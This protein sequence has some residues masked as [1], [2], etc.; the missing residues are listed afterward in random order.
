[1][2]DNYALEFLLLKNSFAENQLLQIEFL[3][4]LII[5]SGVLWIVYIGLHYEKIRE[6]FTV[7]RYENEPQNF[8][9]RIKLYIS[10]PLLSGNGI[11]MWRVYASIPLAITTVIF[12]K[13][14]VVNS[15]L[16]VVYVFLFTTDALDGAVARFLNN[17]TNLGKI[18]DPFADKFLDLMPLCIVS[19]FSGNSFFVLVASLIC[20]IDIA[21]QNLRAKTSNP[22]ANRVGKTKTVFKI[23]TIYIISLNR[24]EIYLDYIGGT[25]LIISLVFTFGSF[26]LKIKDRIF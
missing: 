16:L 11:C 1:M 23:I 10:A 4:S 3:I 15:L 26:W 9:E 7:H 8:S 22:A 21:G 18:L 17:V 20:I 24:Y 5:V 13:E 25:L 6:C 14:M 2:F 12:Y 19:M